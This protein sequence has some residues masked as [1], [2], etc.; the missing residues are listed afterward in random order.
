[1]KNT[2]RYNTPNTTWGYVISFLLSTANRLYVG[3]FGTLMFPLIG[4]AH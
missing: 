3:W 2:F 4:L 1:M